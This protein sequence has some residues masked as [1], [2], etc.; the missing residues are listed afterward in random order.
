MWVGDK[1]QLCQEGG[2][3]RGGE[4]GREDCPCVAKHLY[5]Q[6][7]AWTQAWIG[8]PEVH[9]MWFGGPGDSRSLQPSRNQNESGGES[10][11]AK[12]GSSKL[13]QVLGCS[14]GSCLQVIFSS[15]RYPDLECVPWGFRQHAP[16]REPPPLGMLLSRDLRQTCCLPGASVLPA[17]GLLVEPPCTQEPSLSLLFNKADLYEDSVHK[18]PDSFQI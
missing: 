3:G 5:A 8:E 16:A 6:H 9:S 14:K 17:S 7:W 1:R 11:R 13:Y 2:G 12:I 15:P 18:G 10:A 4:R